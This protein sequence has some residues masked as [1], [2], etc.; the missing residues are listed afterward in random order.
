MRIGLTQSNLDRAW[1]W[2]SEVSS[3]DSAKYGQ[4][5]TAKQV[6]EAFAPSEEAVTT[7]KSWLTSSGI[8]STRIKQSQSLNWLE[9]EATVD[10]AEELFKTKYNVYEHGET[11][12]PHVACEEYSVPAH[13]QEHIDLVYPTVHFDV[14]VKPRMEDDLEDSLQELQK[15]DSSTDGWPAHFR[16]PHKPWQ[17]PGGGWRMPWHHPPA[18]E[19]ANC[20]IYIT[21]TNNNTL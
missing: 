5:W 21:V 2:L 19:L 14:K 18:N 7:V 16:G 17:P 8:H 1:D 11:G 4:H 20:D 10:E 12:Q 13:L 6:A 3:P 15:R 9:F